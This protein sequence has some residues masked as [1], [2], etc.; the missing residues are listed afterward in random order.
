MGINPPPR[1]A[2]CPY[3]V[4]TLSNIPLLDPTPLTITKQLHHFTYLHTAV[5]Q[6]PHCLQ[7]TAPYP[8][9]KLQI[10]MGQISSPIY[11]AHPWTNLTY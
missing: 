4:W 5:P 7:W 11:A 9:P 6:I 8:P 2:Y 3:A 1:I 10:P